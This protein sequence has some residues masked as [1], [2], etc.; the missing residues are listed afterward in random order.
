M[1]SSLT[2][3]MGLQS[4]QKLGPQFSF[5]S[6]NILLG[7]EKLINMIAVIMLVIPLIIFMYGSL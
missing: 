3:V 1:I 6:K 7:L 4:R 5:Y 2:K